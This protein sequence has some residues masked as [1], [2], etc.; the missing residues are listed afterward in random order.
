VETPQNVIQ[1]IM[2]KKIKTEKNDYHRRSG[3]CIVQ[4]V[5]G[6]IDSVKGIIKY[7]DSKG[8]R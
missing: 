2:K 6:T 7:V 3:S 5:N 8:K 4:Y 1:K